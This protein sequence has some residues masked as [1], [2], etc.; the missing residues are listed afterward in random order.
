MDFDDFLRIAIPALLILGPL[1]ARAFSSANQAKHRP[2]AQP[3][4]EVEIN[5]AL[6]EEI[7]EF[8]RRG[9]PRR[10]AQAK[11]L[12]TLEPAVEAEVVEIAETPRLPSLHEDVSTRVEQHLDSSRFQQHSRLLGRATSESDERLEEHLHSVFD[13]QLGQLGDIS[14]DPADRIQIREGTD[15]KEWQSTVE[16]REQASAETARRHDELREMLRRPESLREAIVLS[17]I[18]RRPDEIS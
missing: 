2:E 7:D 17:E 4:D 5:D 14:S 10:V 12:P 18:F 8:L 16:R 13:R 15:A 9:N 1:L 3:R 6:Q 11:S